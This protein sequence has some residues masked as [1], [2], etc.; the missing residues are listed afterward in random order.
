MPG[1]TDHLP[2]VPCSEQ[3]SGS[4]L[5]LPSLTQAQTAM[6][7][8]NA[9]NPASVVSTREA[10]SKRGKAPSSPGV[11]TAEVWPQRSPQKLQLHFKTTISATIFTFKVRAWD[12]STKLEKTTLPLPPVPKGTPACITPELLHH[13]EATG[14]GT[15]CR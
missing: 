11:K 12:K 10:V 15:K 8:S 4:I 9:T 7:H 14:W 3:V 5:S 1:T 6:L 2:G 13:R